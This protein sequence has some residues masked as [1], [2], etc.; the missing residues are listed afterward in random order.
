MDWDGDGIEE[1]IMTYSDSYGSSRI[2]IARKEAEEW[3]PWA[4]LRSPS[5]T[6]LE[7]LTF[8]DMDG[9][10]QTELIAGWVVKQPGNSLSWQQ[11]EVQVY[12]ADNPSFEESEE[13]RLL[14]PIEALAYEAAET[15]DVD[16]DGKQELVLIRRP[17][18]LGKPQIEIYRIDK[19]K[20]VNTVKHSIQHNAIVYRQLAIGKIAKSKFGVIV[21]A[22]SGGHASTTTI[23]A[24]EQNR[25]EQVYPPQSVSIASVADSFPMTDINGDGI[26]EW[27]ELVR[28]PGQ[29]EDTSFSDLVEYTEWLQ[30]SG[31]TPVLGSGAA[32]YY[33]ND[34]SVI[35][36]NSRS[37]ATASGMVTLKPGAEIP[38]EGRSPESGDKMML[39]DAEPEKAKPSHISIAMEYNDLEHG[40]S[41]QIPSRW[42]GKFTLSRPDGEDKAIVQMEYYNAKSGI[43]APLWTLYGVSVKDWDSWSSW[44]EKKGLNPDNLRTTGGFV[45][46]AVKQPAPTAEDGWSEDELSRYNSMQLTR[47]QLAS[48]VRLLPFD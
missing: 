4:V 45:Y 18:N 25:L 16:G 33:S 26:L 9:D 7:W 39:P 36:H 37:A 14:K 10:K 32:S 23:Y 20:L 34:E 47:E 13:G 38:N 2:M 35:Y 6:S 27:S 48:S 41:V 12:S 28:A 19:G 3:K 31:E 17:D 30:W 46:A 5:G 1:A 42:K 15:G 29:P 24:W 8:V 21:E 43:R 11:Y 22:E 44:M 40:I